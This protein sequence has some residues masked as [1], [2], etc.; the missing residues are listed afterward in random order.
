MPVRSAGKNPIASLSYDAS[1]VESET[2]MPGSENFLELAC[3]VVT[4]RLERGYLV[5]I[6]DVSSAEL[7]KP[8]RRQLREN[9]DVKKVR[10]NSDDPP[11]SSIRASEAAGGC[12]HSLLQ[13]VSASASSNAFQNCSV[14]KP[15]GRIVQ[16]SLS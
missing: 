11:T 12:G 13:E 9:Y 4:L 1:V 3:R 16:Y 2:R 5:K 8:L 6:Y 7:T 15:T 10:N 14:V